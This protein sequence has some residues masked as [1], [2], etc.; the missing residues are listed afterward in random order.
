MAVQFIIDSASDILP[1]EAKQL[2]IAAHLPLKVL[3]GEEEYTDA[4]SLSHD[5]FYNKLAA[6]EALPTT[7]QVSPAAFEAAYE[8]VV[9]AGDTAVVVT[10]S[11]KLSGTYQSAV[12][13]AEDYEGKVFVVDSLNATIGERILILRGLQLREQGLSA[14]EIAAQLEED[15]KKIR[16]LAMLD[17]L[18]NLKKGGRISAATALAGGLLNIKPII[19]VEDGLVIMKSKAR[20]AKQGLATLRDLIPGY[21]QVR[22]DLPYA[23]TYSGLTDETARKFASDNAELWP[24]AP[25]TLGI[26]QVGCSIGTHI[27]PGAVGIAYFAE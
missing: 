14:R 5:E 22:F 13:A 7:S 18:E 10:M 24:D 2:G 1:E 26:H 3:F 17:T 4:V 9:A 6:S 16:L 27:G 15:K 23:L 20:G 25:E 19:A 21:G 11:G 8:Q 12:I